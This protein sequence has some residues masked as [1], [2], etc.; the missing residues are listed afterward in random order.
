MKTIHLYSLLGIIVLFFSCDES[1][2]DYSADPANSSGT[3][4]SLARFTIMDNYLYTVD[5]STLKIFDIT[6]EKNPRQVGEIY[7]DVGVQTIFALGDLLFLGTINGINIYNISDPASPQYVS[8][9][10]HVRSCDPVVVKGNYAYSTLSISGSCSQGVNEL[11]IIDISTPEN[12]TRVNIL[13]ME[14]P[15]GLGISGSLLFIC[16][17]GLKVYD[18]TDP[19]DP[20]FLRKITIDA[21]DVIPIDKLLL[22]ATEQGLSEY[23]IDDD[24]QIHFVSS[25]YS[26]R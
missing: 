8:V 3:G 20:Q 13:P 1:S 11:D 4:G 24:N 12:P 16:D 22:V 23:S 15:K 21:T 10:T 6:N 18:L 25:L 26:Y 5:P 14:N 7:I 9:S 2:Y 19:V 17:E